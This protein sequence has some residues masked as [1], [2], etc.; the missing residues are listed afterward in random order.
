MIVGMWR[1]FTFIF[2]IFCVVGLSAQEPTVQAT[3][4]SASD[5]GSGTLT[6]SWTRGDGSNIL[7]LA[8][9]SSAVDATPSDNTSYTADRFGSG[10]Q[11][12]SG[13]FVVYS[14][15]GT[16]TTIRGLSSNT[17]YHFEAFEFN[18]GG[19]PSDP[20]YLLT[21]SPASSTTTTVPLTLYSFQSGNAENATTWTTNSSGATLVNAAVPGP[22][23]AVVVLINRTVTVTENDFDLASLNVNLNSTLDLGGTTGHTFTS[24]DGTGLMRS[25]NE[26]PGSTT[27]NFITTSGGTFEYYDTG[28]AALTTGDQ[29]TY[30][31]LIFDNS[32]LTIGIDLTVNGTFILENDSDIT[33]GD[34]A[35]VRN[36]T[37]TGDVSIDGTSSISIRTGVALTEHLVDIGGDFTNNGSVRFTAQGSP[38]YTADPSVGTAIVTFS[39]AS[40]NVL[41]CNGTTDFYRLILDKGSDRTFLLTVNSSNVSNFELYGTTNDNNTNSA[42]PPD[43]LKAL[44]IRNGTLKLNDNINIVSLTEGS[45]HFYVPSNGGLWV[46]GASVALSTGSSSGGSQGVAVYGLL[47]LTSGTITGGDGPGIN[48]RDNA[49]ILIEGGVMTLAQFRRAN[50]GSANNKASYTQTGGT[51][52]FNGVGRNNANV[53]RFDMESTDLSEAQSSFTMTSGT[54]IISDP[55]ATTGGI[56]IQ[57]RPQDF[58]VTG[59]TIIAEVT[60]ANN[61]GITLPGPLHNL[62]LREDGD[63]ATGDIRPMNDLIDLTN[64][65]VQNDLILDVGVEL[66]MDD[67]SLTIGG[68]LTINSGTTYTPG[69][70]VTQ[71]NGDASQTL[72]IEGAITGGF[73]DVTVNKS[74]GTLGVS[75]SSPATIAINDELTLSGGTFD[76]NGKIIT[77][78]GNLQNSAT[79]TGSGSIQLNGTNT[80]IISGDGSGTFQNLNLLNTNAATAPISTSA[81]ITVN[82][83]LTFSNDKLLNIGA[84]NLS[85]GIAGYSSGQSTA[86]YIQTAGN[87]SDGGV[88]K[89][90]SEN[91]TG[92]VIPV[93]TSTDYLPATYTFTATTFGSITVTPV[94]TNHPILGAGN[95]GVGAYWVVSESGWVIPSVTHTYQYPTNGSDGAYR[96]GRYFSANWNDLGDAGSPGQVVEGSDQLTITGVTYFQGE[97]TAADA[98]S[99]PVT[100]Y[101]RT[102]GN[103]GDAST[104]STVTHGGVTAVTTPGALDVVIIGDGDTNNYTVT[105]EADTKHAAALT[106]ASGS[107]LNLASTSG[108]T[109]ST[110]DG[111]GTLRI[112]SANFPSGDASAFL[113]ASGGTVEYFDGASDYTIPDISPATYNNLT[114][115]TNGNRRITMPDQSITVHNNFTIGSGTN[116]N[117]VQTS[118]NASAG[119]ITINGNLVIES[120]GFLRIRDGGSP[121]TRNITI[122]GDLNIEGDL[123]PN[124]TTNSTGLTLTIYGNVVNNGALDL[125]NTNVFVRTVFTSVDNTTI[126]GTGATMDFYS[127]EV[128]KG[129]SASSLLEVTSSNFALLGDPGLILTN[130]TFRLTTATTITAS[131]TSLTI[132]STAA[133]SVNGGTIDIA[134]GAANAND[135]LLNGEL[136]VIT[137][138]VNVGNAA[139]DNNND[140]EYAS[141]GTPTIDIQ[142]GTL[143]VNGQIRRSAVNTNGSLT[144]S[145]S[146]G[147]VT[148]NGRNQ[149]ATRGKLEVANNGVFNM[150]GSSTLTIVRGGGTSFDDLHLRPLSSTVSGGSIVFSPGTSGGQTYTMDSN[151]ALNDLI[152][153]GN[154]A[155]NTATVEL[156]VFGLTLNGGLTLSEANSTLNTN[157]LDV[158]IGG[159][160]SNNGAYNVGTGNTTF[161]GPGAQL[162]IFNTAISF[163]DL[164]VNKPSGTLTFSGTNDPAVN[165]DL[166]ISSGTLED[167]GR[168]INVLGNVINNA[169]HSSGTM[170]VGGIAFSDA[171]HNMSGSGAFGN[172]TLNGTGRTVTVGD[173]ITING[174]LD[175]A[176]TVVMDISNNALAFDELSTISGSSFSASKMIRTSSNNGIIKNYPASASSFT[177]PVGVST[178]YT[179]VTVNLTANSATGTVTLALFNEAHPLTTDAASTEL[180]YYY[181]LSSTGLSGITADLTFN[182]VQGDVQGAEG[183]YFAGR[184]TGGAWTPGGGE[185]GLVN[186]VNNTISYTGVNFVTGD[187]TAGET[188]EFGTPAVYYSRNA[189]AGS[190]GD[191]WENASAWTF[192][193][194]GT[195][196]APLPLSAPV[197]NSVTIGSGHSVTVT[198]S[199]RSSFELILNGTL[200]LGSTI[201]HTF[202]NVTGTGELSLEATPSNNFNFPSADISA[203]LGT[204]NYTG[205]TNDG[206]LI[207]TP[208][209]FNAISFTGT[210]AKSLQNVAFDITGTWNMSSGT[211]NQ[212]NNTITTLNGDFNNT[213]ATFNASNGTMVLGGT[214]VQNITTS[215]GSSTFNNLTISNT[216]GTVNL[217]N[218]IAVNGALTQNASTSMDLNSN[219]ITGTGDITINGT[220]N[221]S[222]A[223]GLSGGVSTSFANT[224]N[225][226]TLN[227]GSNIVYDLAGAQTIS[228][229]ADYQGLEVGG[230][231]TKSLDGSTTISGNLNIAAGDLSIGANLLSLNG[232]LSGAG[233]ITGSATSDIV[234]GGTG[235]LGTIDFTTG[236]ETL[237]D[238]TMNRSAAGI[239]NVNEDFTIRDNLVL[240]D[241][242]IMMGVGSS[243]TLGASGNVANVTGGSSTSYI[244]TDPVDDDDNDTGIGVSFYLSTDEFHLPIGFN[245]YFPIAISCTGCDGTQSFFGRVRRGPYNTPPSSGGRVRDDVVRGMWE[246]WL[247]S[248]TT[249]V[250]LGIQLSWDGSEEDNTL[251][252]DVGISIYDTNLPLASRFWNVGDNI[253]PKA[254]SNPYFKERDVT[255]TGNGSIYFAITNDVSPLPVTLI[256]FTGQLNN[257]RA[258][259]LNW[260]TASE[261]DNDHFSV[262][263]SLDGGQTF[264]DIGFVPGNGSTNALHNYSFTDKSV[265]NQ[266]GFIHYRLKQVDFSGA[267]E[268]SPIVAVAIHETTQASK[269]SWRFY[270]NPTDGDNFE[271]VLTDSSISLKEQY[272]FRLV[273]ASGL[274]IRSSKQGIKNASNWVKTQLKE[275]PD[276]MYFLMIT[277]PGKTD[278]LRL[279]K[280]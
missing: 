80:Q 272:M 132:P 128:N 32:D 33:I 77:V 150:S 115:N 151:I 190:G 211:I 43:V 198:T 167:G 87:A 137:G 89:T 72:T 118:Q 176:G 129:T 164:I 271:L 195:D 203:F 260:Q 242:R 85:F 41:T 143:F 196:S 110:V 123:R 91:A 145:Q 121:I 18:T 58:S 78:S 65:E 120:G 194:D 197:G 45:K 68:N 234:V 140:I 5:V 276:G 133:L 84:N 90:F 243:V 100:Y 220:V 49:E 57:T 53:A 46:D 69:T 246:I 10:S 142:G 256:S 202:G 219:V 225:S 22:E 223:N 224:L 253:G 26:F 37:W 28:V 199:T 12:G 160:F 248:G 162:A 148:I 252:N 222:N 141:I 126:S 214:G 106:I 267:F 70:N 81:N 101:A 99:D 180:L 86:R 230:S 231:G 204:V 233:T 60:D 74:S 158:I 170:G 9:A 273:D 221:T 165:S 16:S 15:T 175:F 182:Y 19:A 114:V 149:L 95:T 171:D 254:G 96:A 52:T 245:P 263:R 124:N 261:T 147:A 47:R 264:K 67:D 153:T 107:T 172:I 218:D 7:I 265:P 13:N 189:T 185:A 255:F 1:S 163:D 247:A 229:R 257:E 23:D 127:I 236:G 179:P 35:T 235:T 138:A 155:G 258:V 136:E 166:T 239:V 240:T 31:N 216:S 29:L 237:G 4:L 251:G 188:G 215:S 206:N 227:S 181:R 210:S 56:S 94:S 63:G 277:T 205:S 208:P 103:W 102:D 79:H 249:P 269:P 20:D 241:G 146:A 8:K 187:F 191:N 122:L 275:I 200:N 212:T 104:W 135:L 97:F 125:A 159:D 98:F 36:I 50:S 207:N 51:V 2:L 144:Y 108:H 54:L 34:D 161:N 6:L 184:V 66:F 134:T 64:L 139:N 113:G 44:W 168:T 39:G 192:N 24:L 169:S 83:V 73:N 48:Y 93:G 92:Y 259:E 178:D 193:S 201:N 38:N 266:S 154:G 55:N 274:V 14:G 177:Y 11:I 59:G 111:V 42:N 279:I 173:A 21:S 61:F 40:D 280:R 250:T 262:Q 71:F 152:I 232:T 109:F 183:S 17:T 226:V 157:N 209:S 130:G 270:P 217:M 268:F 76:D 213:G 228:A 82:G 174:D 105:A 25:T 238:F 30:N 156:D 186:S 112:S 75:T 131:S 244:G 278:R 88:T 3:L 117:R 27:N 119:D 62:T 116:T